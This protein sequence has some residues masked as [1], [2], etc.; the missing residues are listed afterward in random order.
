MGSG[1]DTFLSRLE[2]KVIGHAE[3]A[4]ARPGE[5]LRAMWEATTSASIWH[6]VG[7]HDEVQDSEVLLLALCELTRRLGLVVNG[8]TS[9]LGDIQEATVRIL[10]GEVPSARSPYQWQLA[11][12]PI[13]ESSDA[14]CQLPPWAGPQQEVAQAVQSVS[15]TVEEIRDVSEALSAMEEIWQSLAHEEA[16]ARV[17]NQICAGVRVIR[18]LR[19]SPLAVGIPGR[20]GLLRGAGNAIVP[21]VAAE[22]IRAYQEVTS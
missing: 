20:T 7:G 14:L 4:H 17:A 9:C 6:D 18:A 19:C 11:G 13:G 3:K 10:W 16:T 5:V 12:S 22:F 1:W 2:K 15:A 8:S 21:P